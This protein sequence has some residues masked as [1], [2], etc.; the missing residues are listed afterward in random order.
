MI[1][2]ILPNKFPPLLRE[3]KDAP[4][5]LFVR[6]ELDPDD[7]YI[8]IVGTRKASSYGKKITVR[9]A[10]ELARMGMTV[11]SGLAIGIDMYAHEAALDNGGRTIAV[12]GCGLDQ[13][14]PP[15]NRK[16]A[17]RILQ[18]GAII[19]EYPVNV[20]PRKFH[21]PARNRI[22]SGMSLATIVIEA[23]E[24]SGALI[25]GR[26]A[27]DQGREVF[28]VPGD[29]DRPQS[30][31]ALQL[32]KEGAHPFTCVNDIFENL[33]LQ[34]DLLSCLRERR[35][36]NLSEDELKVMNLIPKAGEASF[37]SVIRAA[38]MHISKVQSII[39]I[40]EIRGLIEQ[41]QN[42]MFVRS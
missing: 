7:R 10:G 1:S 28:A 41:T 29:I 39:S 31:G 19:S 6:G 37:E 22:I 24:K 15:E 27:S 16:L 2:T 25:T 23:G 35:I 9:V 3:I 18:N 17:D 40:L 8:A 21:F 26:K 14:Y 20:E 12:L 33:N 4:K 11:V 34:T 38:D 13:I 5:E 36:E 42:G 32:L 30:K